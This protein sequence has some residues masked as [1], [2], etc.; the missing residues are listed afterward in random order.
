MVGPHDA[1][2][3]AVERLDLD[4]LGPLVG[5]QH[6]AE[7]AGQHLRKIDDADSVEGA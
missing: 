6:G 3:V 7:R 4:D 5:Q 2:V 1:R